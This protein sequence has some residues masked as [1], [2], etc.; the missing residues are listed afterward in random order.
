[1][2]RFA[3]V[4]QLQEAKGQQQEPLDDSTRSDE[5]DKGKSAKPAFCPNNDDDAKDKDHVV[6]VFHYAA[7]EEEEEEE[8]LNRKEAKKHE[9]YL[10][11]YILRRITHL[12]NACFT[13]QEGMLLSDVHIV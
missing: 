11:N 7:K 10:S 2:D 6:L 1:W 4:V 8:K 5:K 12:I 13:Q 9:I 3:Q